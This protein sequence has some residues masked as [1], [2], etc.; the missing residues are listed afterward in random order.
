MIYAITAS[1]DATLY[2][3]E[4]RQNTGLDPIL[5]LAKVED[6]NTAGQYN[7]SRFLIQFDL[8]SISSSIVN[9]DI[10]NPNFY[11]KVYETETG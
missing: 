11:L 2:E 8:N 4:S 3:S 5:Q 6:T 9:G 10:T 7:N 1:K